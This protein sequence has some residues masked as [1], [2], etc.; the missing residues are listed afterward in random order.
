[1][2]TNQNNK[3]LYPRGSKWRRW[4]LHVHSD[5]GSPEEIVDKLIEK[6]I[7][8]FS[9]TDHSNVDKIDKFL[10]IVRQRQKAK[11]E[12]YFLP[13]VELK[14]DKGKKSVHLIGIFPLQDKEGNKID[15]DYLKQNLL[16][17]I[18]CSDAD[19]IKAGKEVLREGLSEEEYR[20]SC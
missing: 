20:K 12:I 3:I 6:G 13:G 8:V 5:S 16:S 10:E 1:M 7:S 19:I 17:K 11:K 4:D 18:D 9:I 2:G 14:T 15:S